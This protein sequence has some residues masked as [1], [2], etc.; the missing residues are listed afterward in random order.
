VLV[1]TD[2]FVNRFQH[3]CRHVPYRF[4]ARLKRWNGRSPAAGTAVIAGKDRW[5]CA[6]HAAAS[7][8]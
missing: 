3:P 8:A 6:R 1:P 2:A 4:L 7:S 5:K